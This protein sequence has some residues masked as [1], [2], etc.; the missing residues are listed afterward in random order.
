MNFISSKKQVKRYLD[1]LLIELNVNKAE[2]K[3]LIE[4]FTKTLNC[5]WSL[6]NLREY[7]VKMN[8]IFDK[9][10]KEKLKV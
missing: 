5:Y 9:Y 1:D 2:D 6:Y 8:E 4:K 3:N 7:T 10:G